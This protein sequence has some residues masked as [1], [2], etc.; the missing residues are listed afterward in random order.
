ME[1]CH[2]LV[3]FGSLGKPLMNPISQVTMNP[4]S[5]VITIDEPNHKIM[6]EQAHETIKNASLILF[7]E[8]C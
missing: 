4:I 5:Q 7:S 8:L 2:H 1:D 3:R 6:H